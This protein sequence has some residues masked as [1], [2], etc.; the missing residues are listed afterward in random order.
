MTEHK[1]QNAKL[2]LRNEKGVVLIVVI[3]LSAVSLVIM[4][5]LIYMITSGTQLSGLKKRYATALEAGGGGGDVFYQLIATRAETA[6]QASLIANLNTFGLNVTSTTPPECTGSDLIS[7][8]T[9]TGLAAKLFTSSTTWTNCDS[10][11]TIDPATASTYDMKM[12]LGATTKYNVYAKIVATT[13]GNSGGGNLS[14]L[15]QG[16][17]SSN[18]GVVEAMPLPYLYAIE[19]VSEN[20]A[21]SDERAKL[22]VLYQY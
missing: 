13:D 1:T 18:S 14:L 21:Q 8:A 16:A 15:N 6:D 7:G 4:T 12:E 17:V 9:Y 3:I 11:L 22:S 20:S 10:S 5:A 2:K 19:L